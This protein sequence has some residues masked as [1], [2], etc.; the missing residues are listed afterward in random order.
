MPVFLNIVHFITLQ[1]NG[2]MVALN[3][4]VKDLYTFEADSLSSR[5][6]SGEMLACCFS[7]STELISGEAVL[8]LRAAFN[9]SLTSQ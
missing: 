2:V 6:H 4:N 1:I 8:P 5:E 7:L 9:P 3:T